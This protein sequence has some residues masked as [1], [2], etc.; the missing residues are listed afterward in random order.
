MK[1]AYKLVAFTLAAVI[2]APITSFAQSSNTPVTRAQVK[3]EL[4]QLERAGYRPNKVK[5]PADIQAAEARVA[6][7]GGQAVSARTDV[8]GTSDGSSQAGN[9]SPANH[10]H[11]LYA[12]H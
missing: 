7:Q 10:R 1:H 2:S 4:V 11:S 8:G 9:H 3:N 12:H 5:Y 6:A